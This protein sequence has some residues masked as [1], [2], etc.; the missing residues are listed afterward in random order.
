MIKT[1]ANIRTDSDI[2]GIALAGFIGVGLI[3]AA[4]FS[5]AQVMH[6]VSHDSRHAIAFPCH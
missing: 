4:G 3:F 5:H 6:D 1:F 2:L